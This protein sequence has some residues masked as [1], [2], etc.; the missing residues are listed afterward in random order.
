MAS[1][2]SM[3]G[4]WVLAAGDGVMEMTCPGTGNTML[5]SYL[6]TKGKTQVPYRG[7]GL[8][9]DDMPYAGESG[10]EGEGREIVAVGRHKGGSHIKWQAQMQ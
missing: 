4:R 2:A 6:S 10:G 3:N 9:R 7:R 8:T 5:I 1:L